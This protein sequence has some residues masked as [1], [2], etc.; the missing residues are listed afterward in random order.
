VSSQG[1]PSAPPAWGATLDALSAQARTRAEQLGLPTTAL[2]DWRYVQLAPLKTAIDGAQTSVTS[3]IVDAHALPGTATLV[4]VDGRFKPEL[5]NLAAIPSAIAAIDLLAL[6]LADGT[7]LAERWRA[8]LSAAADI[9]A[10]WALGDCAGGLRLRVRGIADRPLHLLSFATGGRSAAR[11]VVGLDRSAEADLAISHVAL[12]RSRSTVA[13]EVAGAEGSALRIDESQRGT[14]AAQ[15]QVFP[16]LRARLA[17]DAR[18]AYAAARM[19]AELGRAR[20]EVDL[21]APGASAELAS[22]AA[23]DGSRQWHDLVRV[24]HHAGPSSSTQLF[25]NLAGGT[26]VA[27]FDGLV[28]ID[29]GA[30]RSE[31]EQRNQNLLLTPKAR[32]DTRPQLDILADDVKASHGATVGQLS[33][34]ELFYLRARGLPETLARSLLMRGFALEAVERLRLPA[35]RDLVERELLAG[36]PSSGAPAA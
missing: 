34:D 17:R 2:E 1:G 12:G 29:R 24:R 16:L 4:L 15:A 36:S 5:S 11:V 30:D 13:I 3:A 20:I 9:T 7:V 18:L 23:L 8:E 22:L 25:K 10:C 21:D 35:M 27:S 14:A 32:V 31:A 6:P 26:S 19:G 28:A 33:A